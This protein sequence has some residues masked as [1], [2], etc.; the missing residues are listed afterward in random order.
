MSDLQFM[1]MVDGASS[2]DI[3]RVLVE[4]GAETKKERTLLLSGNLMDVRANEDA[5]PSL[6]DGSDDEWQH[7]A[8]VVESY[9]TAK[10][11][12]EDD[13]VLLAR[14]IREALRDEGMSVEIAASFEARL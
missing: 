8:W 12:T 1:A 14:K 10:T 9:P 13:Q 7:Y 3:V 6:V 4:V 11:I 2:N 5:D